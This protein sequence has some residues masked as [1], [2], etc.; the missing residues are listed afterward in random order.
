[1]QRFDHATHG[2]SG[3]PE[4]AAEIA[5]APLAALGRGQGVEEVE[6]GGREVQSLEGA[7]RDS[8][9]AL[10]GALHS[11]EDGM[12]SGGPKHDTYRA[13]RGRSSAR[14]APLGTRVR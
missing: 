3:H 8:Q 2:G 1:Y 9:G 12:H 6:A 5:L 11:E 13:M 7:P 10:V 4:P 14:M